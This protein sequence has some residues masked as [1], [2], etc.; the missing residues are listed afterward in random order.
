LAAACQ[1][2]AQSSARTPVGAREVSPRPYD[3]IAGSNEGSTLFF[4]DPLDSQVDPHR[5][6]RLKLVGDGL[7]DLR[8][9]AAEADI[10]RAA[11]F[12]G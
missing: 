6:E 9:D 4:V 8:G 1:S 10:N 11:G 7:A 5:N 12:L 3:P 2:A